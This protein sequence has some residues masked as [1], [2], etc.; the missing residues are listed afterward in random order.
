M[1]GKAASALSEILPPHLK[2]T[3]QMRGM[4]LAKIPLL[5]FVAPSVVEVSESRCEV[6]IPLN[7][8]TKNHLG[9]M[10][11]GA[12]AIGADCAGGLIAFQLIEQANQRLRKAGENSRMDLIFKDFNAAFLKRPEGDV[13]FICEEGRQIAD[14]VTHANKTGERQS[15]P[16]HVKALCP[17]KLGDEPVAEFTLTLSVKKSARKG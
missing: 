17:A 4:S 3:L 15:M 1:I 2:H 11:F 7:W 5:F 6:R 10:Y 9:S 12:L 8:R 16:V 13:H 14:L